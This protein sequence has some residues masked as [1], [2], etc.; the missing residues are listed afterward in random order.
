MTFAR[1]P[2]VE[3]VGSVAFAEMSAPSFLGLAE[4]WR[5]AWSETFPSFDL[6]PRYAVPHESFASKVGGPGA[7]SVEMQ[8]VPP[9]PRVWLTSADQQH[10]MQVQ[11]DWFAV[12]W[13]RKDAAGDYDRWPARRA[14]F[15]ARWAE[16]SE[17]LR[18]R[19]ENTDPTQFEVTYIN[20]IHPVQGV[21]ATHQ[22]ISRVFPGL[23][24]NASGATTLEQLE[25]RSQWLVPAAESVGLPEARLHVRAAPGFVGPGPEPAPIFVLELTVRGA[26]A[27]GG[28]FGTF[29]DRARSIIVESFM[30]LTA[31]ELH[32]AWG[33]Q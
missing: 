21:W 11:S 6:R 15:E 18:V 33:K 10:L 7:V 13:R 17:W 29:G 16:F 22:D 26:P 19:G 4:L 5:G 30:S 32:K 12:N 2:V 27:P 31:D 1:P 24:S 20:H 25:T 3:V 8:A 9:F 23:A 14:A 28:E